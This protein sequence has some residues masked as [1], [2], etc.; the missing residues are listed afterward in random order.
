M[1]IH[2]TFFKW[3]DIQNYRALV[4]LNGILP[5]QSFFQECTIRPLIAVDGSA[6]QL[7]ANQIPYDIVIGDLDSIQ[8]PVLQDVQVVHLPH[9]SQSDFEKLID[10]L[11]QK[12]LFP[13][14]ILG[15]GGGN[16]DHILNNI[17]LFSNLN[18]VFYSP[19]ILGFMIKSNKHFQMFL[20]KDTKISLIPLPSAIVSSKGLKWELNQSDLSFPG[21]NSC[22]NRTKEENILISVQHGQVLAL[23]YTSAIDD[24]GIT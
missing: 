12:N 11:N 3:V 14:I 5:D 1:T 2:E 4:C 22:F 13:A 19:P 21:Q 16:L 15:V 18:C 10:Y 17:N 8:H 23:L 7:F 9:Q 6:N 24:A 20:P